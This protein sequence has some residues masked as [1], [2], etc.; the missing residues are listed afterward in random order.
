MLTDAERAALE[1]VRAVA[2]APP[3][4]ARHDDLRLLVAVIDRMAEAPATVA[5]GLRAVLDRMDAGM[6]TAEP[7]V[8]RRIEGALVAVEILSSPDLSSREVLERL[9]G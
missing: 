9:T 4:V 2:L 7:A 8:E 3:T 6:L 1:R 5:G